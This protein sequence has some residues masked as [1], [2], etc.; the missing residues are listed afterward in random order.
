MKNLEWYLDDGGSGAVCAPSRA[1]RAGRQRVGAP[2]PTPEALRGRLPATPVVRANVDS[3]RRQLQ[4]I[5]E[6]RDPRRMV[7]VG[8]CSIHDPDAARD[9]ARRLAG[10]ARRVRDVFCV[11]MRVYFEKP[12]TTVGWKGLINDPR[13]DGSHRIEE[14]LATARQLLL[15]VNTLGLPAAIEALDL[16]TPH[17]LGDLVSWAAIGARTTESQVHREMASGLP[18]PVGFKNGT[19]GGLE[20]AVHALQSSRRAHAFIG[21]DQRGG[22]AVLHTEGNP[23]GHVVLRG[24]N[25]GPNHDAASVAAAEAALVARDLPA[26]LVVDCSHAN[27]AKQHA[28]QVA[29]LDD[30]VEQIGAG[31]RSIR[32]VMIESFIE[33]GNQPLGA[34]PASLRYGCSITDP[35]LGWDATE[36]AL[37]QARERLLAHSRRAG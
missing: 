12:R 7:I 27:C 5:L 37:V 26:N 36:A 11:V 19:D 35:C 32:G 20:V 30:V 16:V 28:L 14:G 31:N 3:G 33:A 21:I 2:L 25:D 29:V 4:A 22:P 34:D 17:Y 10:L 24:G 23:H 1:E 8:P 9:Y 15:D 13:L 6:R 18:M